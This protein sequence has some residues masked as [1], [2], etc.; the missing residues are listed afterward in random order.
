MMI[1]FK[2]ILVDVFLPPDRVLE[3]LLQIRTVGYD[4]VEREELEVLVDLVDGQ[5]LEKVC[6]DSETVI[7][8]FLLR[9]RVLGHRYLVKVPFLSS[10][11]LTAFGDLRFQN[12]FVLDH[13]DLS[14]FIQ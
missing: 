9:S 7:H 3:H 8:L 4:Q 2:L 13:R 5:I 11:G 12:I 10:H 1:V 14:V 6:V